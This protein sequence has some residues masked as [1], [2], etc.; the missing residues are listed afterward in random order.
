MKKKIDVILLIILVSYFMTLLDNS[1]VFTGS[2]KIAEDLHLSEVALTWVSNA[3]TLTYAGFLLLGGKLGDNFGRKRIYQ[4]GLII[5][6]LGSLLTGL[7]T[8]ADLIIG[9]R[10]FQGIGS[11]ILAPTT[12]ALL[13]DNYQGK[14]RIKAIGAYGTTAGI[15]ASLG[16][17]IGGLFASLLTWLDGFYLNVPISILLFV[18]SV[19]YLKE[20]KANKNDE[21]LDIVGAFL[22]VLSLSFL[23]F[24]LVGHFYSFTF[25]LGALIL[26]VGFVIYEGKIK[27]PMMPLHLFNDRGRVGAFLVL[28]SFFGAMLTMWYLVPQI[29]QLELGFTP[30]QAGLGF[31]PLTLVNFVVALF[32][33]PLTHKYGNARLLLAGLLITALGLLYLSSFTKSEGYW[34]GIGLPMLILGLGQGLCFSPMTVAGIE[35]VNANEAG[36]GSGLVNM[37][38]TTGGALVM[39]FVISQT[40]KHAQVGQIT[41]FGLAIFLT[42]GCLIF[43]SIIT[44]IFILPGREHYAFK[45]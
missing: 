18:L 5:F 31:F 11:A 16:L 43:A 37:I 12:L 42:F 26:L 33:A 27:S 40:Q 34:L 38:R 20:S 6:A 7:S 14:A 39:S 10:A 28:F 25:A 44:L 32:V 1:I 4:I 2:L 13:M 19:F 9:A 45:A 35:R 24:A 17:V 36:I 15:G 30:L 23:V 21:K 3:Y 8:N 22:S 41:H 29:L